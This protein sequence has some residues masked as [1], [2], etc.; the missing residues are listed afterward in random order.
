MIQL[1]GKQISGSLEGHKAFKIINL[2]VTWNAGTPSVT[3][4]PSNEAVALTDNGAGDLTVTFTDASL[5]PLKLVG[6]S[7]Q[8]ADANT[9]S[10]EMNIDGAPTTTAIKLVYNSGADGATETDPVAS[11]LQIAKVVVA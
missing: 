8:V 10:L 5:V 4:N 11:V 9:L 7:I 2:E 3:W 6:Y 1:D